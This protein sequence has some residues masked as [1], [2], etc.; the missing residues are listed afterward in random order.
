MA[1]VKKGKTNRVGVS[2][3]VVVRSATIRLLRGVS[4]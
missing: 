1:D 4:W 2:C 3:Q